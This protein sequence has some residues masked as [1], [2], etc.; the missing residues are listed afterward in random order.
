MTHPQTSDLTQA[1]EAHK[2]D[3]TQFR[4]AE[5]VQVAYELLQKYDFI[6]AAA[7]YAKGIRTL[8]AAA[9]APQKFNLTI[10]YAFMS[11]IA[12]RQAQSHNGGFDGFV[13][14]NPDLMSKD[15]LAQWYGPERLTSDTARSVFLMPEPAFNMRAA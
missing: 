5:H 6:D 13:S 7:I 9:G 11:L 8:A 12:E 10:T 2:I 3:N 14:A 15:V 1:F 4:H